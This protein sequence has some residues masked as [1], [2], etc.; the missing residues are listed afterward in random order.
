MLCFII[1]KIYNFVESLIYYLYAIYIFGESLNQKQASW[2]AGGVAS[3]S[4]LYSKG[5]K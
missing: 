2:R 3:F 5:T 4:C 1:Y